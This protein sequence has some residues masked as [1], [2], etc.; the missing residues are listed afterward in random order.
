MTTFL[1]ILLVADL[2]VVVYYRLMVRYCYEKQY[3]VK[4]NAFGALFSFAPYS[5]LDPMGRRYARRHIGAVAVML[6]VVL[7]LVLFTDVRLSFPEAAV[8]LSENHSPAE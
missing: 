5:R 8:A 7:S 4:E 2:Y 6:L 1:A 3:G